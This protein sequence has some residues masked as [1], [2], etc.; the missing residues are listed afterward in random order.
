M[1]FHHTSQQY[2]FRHTKLPLRYCNR[3][4]NSALALFWYEEAIYPSS[5]SS[6]LLKVSVK[7]SS[8]DCLS[9]IRRERHV[10]TPSSR[11][12]ETSLKFS[13]LRSTFTFDLRAVVG[14]KFSLYVSSQCVMLEQKRESVR[15][16]TAPRRWTAGGRRWAPA[17][18][19]G[20]TRAPSASARCSCR[21]AHGRAGTKV[22]VFTVE[23]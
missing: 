16:P 5:L 22:C 1:W 20:G 17:A 8:P 23:V 2:S 10:L 21:S 15:C 4:N 13:S 7:S 6:W 11:S 14:N 9:L 19:A 12:T 18:A 3:K